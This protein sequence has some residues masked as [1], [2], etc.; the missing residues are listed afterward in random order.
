MEEVASSK[1]LFYKDELF[2][3]PSILSGDDEMM[4]VSNIIIGNETI[5][6]SCR[7]YNVQIELMQKY[8]RLEKD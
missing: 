4:I 3:Y 6:S 7:N 2:L 8:V 5:K 1:N